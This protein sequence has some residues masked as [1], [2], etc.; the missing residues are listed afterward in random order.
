MPLLKQKKDHYKNHNSDSMMKRKE[1]E[2][3]VDKTWYDWDQEVA[4]CTE[5]IHGML[6]LLVMTIVQE[7]W[8]VVINWKF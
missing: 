7:V 2:N 3:Y 8:E 6:I 5:V 4:F 1:D